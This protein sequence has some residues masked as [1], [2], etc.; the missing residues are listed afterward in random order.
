ME[1]HEG[2][3]PSTSTDLSQTN[4]MIGMQFQEDFEEWMGN[5]EY[6]EQEMQ[7]LNQGVSTGPFAFDPSRNDKSNKSVRGLVRIFCRRRRRANDFV[8]GKL[9]SGRFV[10]GGRKF[11]RSFKDGKMERKRE[12]ER[13]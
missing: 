8:L 10:C 7:F 1:E 13:G 3:D 6:F 5:E 2:Q 9:K 11:Q 12:Q 4:G